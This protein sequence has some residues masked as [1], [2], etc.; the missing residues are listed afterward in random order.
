MPTY[1]I[2]G[3]LIPP[4]PCGAPT[5]DQVRRY[6][7]GDLATWFCLMCQVGERSSPAGRIHWCRS[8]S[9]SGGRGRG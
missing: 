2:H 1:W 7:G 6:G 3:G 8:V 4:C 9:T 5:E